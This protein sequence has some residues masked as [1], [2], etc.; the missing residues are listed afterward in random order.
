MT[1]TERSLCTGD[2]DREGFMYRRQ[3]YGGGYVHCT[4]RGQE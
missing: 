4:Y 1:G 3:G 2:R